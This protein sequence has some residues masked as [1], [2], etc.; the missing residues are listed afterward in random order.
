MPRG[1][2]AAVD[3]H[4]RPMHIRRSRDGWGQLVRT[5]PRDAAPALPRHRDR[6]TRAERPNVTLTCGTCG[7]TFT[8]KQY[9]KRHAVVNFCCQACRLDWTK[10]QFSNLYR[11]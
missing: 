6:Y 9:T 11:P 3:P 10:R 2:H 5:R 7:T 4:V 8:P 1:P